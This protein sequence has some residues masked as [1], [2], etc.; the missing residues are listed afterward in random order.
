MSENENCEFVDFGAGC[1][2]CVEAVF[3]RLDGVKDVVSGYE[4]GETHNPTY[5]QICNGDTGHAEVVRVTFHPERISFEELLD[6]FWKMHDPTTLNRQGADQGTQYRSAIFYQNFEQR[7][8]AEKSKTEASEAFADPIVTEISP[9][10]EFYE[11]EDYH[12]DYFRLNPQAPYCSFVIT[13]KLQ[14]LGC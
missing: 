1:F 10:S 11:A 5:K 7:D 9:A 3:E 2:W 4:G 13:P 12:Q 14:K 8:A 6:V